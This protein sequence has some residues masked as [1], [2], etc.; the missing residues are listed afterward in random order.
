MKTNIRKI[1]KCFKRV[2]EFPGKFDLANWKYLSIFLRVFARIA[3]VAHFAQVMKFRERAHG[4]I[5]SRK[6]DKNNRESTVF[7]F[8]FLF[9][10]FLIQQQ[11]KV[12]CP[13][14]DTTAKTKSL[15]SLLFCSLCFSNGETFHENRIPR[16]KLKTKDIAWIIFTK[17]SFV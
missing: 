3:K 5:D 13:F 9:F 10:I 12:Y 11:N 17:L 1:T 2:K 8:R 14:F 16:E 6:V 7:L 4:K 15:L